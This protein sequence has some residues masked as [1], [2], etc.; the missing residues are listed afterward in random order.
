LR[1]WLD[2]NLADVPDA[3]FV[4]VDILAVT[5]PVTKPDLIV[6]PLTTPTTDAAALTMS[7]ELKILYKTFKTKLCKEA[8]DKGDTS[9]IEAVIED[10]TNFMNT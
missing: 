6:I 3:D 4:K 5:L 10:L 9:D 1:A 8:L 2:T 7:D